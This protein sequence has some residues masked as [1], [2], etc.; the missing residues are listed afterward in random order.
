MIPFIITTNKH[1]RKRIINKPNLA[2]EFFY[3]TNFTTKFST[4]SIQIQTHKPNSAGL[5]ANKLYFL[6]KMKK[7]VLEQGLPSTALEG[8]RQSSF[9]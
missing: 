8:S 7:K 4:M 9:G 2:L 3:Q 1:E 6:Q 5:K